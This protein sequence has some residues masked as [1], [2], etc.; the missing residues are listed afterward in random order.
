MRLKP[1][2]ASLLMMAS[3]SLLA[4]FSANGETWTDSTGQF[5]VEAEFKGV[6]GS[7]VVLLKDNGVTITVPIAKLSEESR[8]LAK[9][10]YDKMKGDGG[11]I[12]QQD[13]GANAVAEKTTIPPRK[14]DFEA[15][16]PP[17][18]S[19]M[20]AFPEDT[21]LQETVDFVKAQLEAG[22]LEVLWHALPQEMRDELDS[23]E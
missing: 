15:P 1:I 13:G 6:E 10:L 21:S 5:T 20:P 16:V 7:S 22:H 4:P 17:T 8:A 11:G 9:G 2:S 3:I 14:L 23:P 19:A 18:L 12:P